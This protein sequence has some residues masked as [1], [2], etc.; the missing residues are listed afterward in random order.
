MKDNEKMTAIPEIS[1]IQPNY[2]KI[3][4]RLKKK[5]MFHFLVASLSPS[6][7][8]SLFSSLLR[9]DTLISSIGHRFRHETY[10][11]NHISFL[12]GELMFLL[13]YTPTPIYEPP[14]YI[15]IPPLR[16]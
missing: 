9:N 12:E 3:L 1:N 15:G 4:V 6:V 5:H 8:V 13:T 2:R 16:R 10:I 14:V 7:T 11:Q